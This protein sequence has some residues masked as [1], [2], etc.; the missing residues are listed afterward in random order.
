MRYWTQ[1]D[2]NRLQS[3]WR[4]DLDARI[5]ADYFKR[6]P[7]AVYCCARRYGLGRK[8]RMIGARNVSGVELLI[9]SLGLDPQ[10][11]KEIAERTVAILRSYEHDAF[12]LR[13]RLARIETKIDAVTEDDEDDDTRF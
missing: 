11:L 5:A 2:V 4:T 1:N 3:I 12:D 9:K 6:S 7:K 8:P 13:E 10:L